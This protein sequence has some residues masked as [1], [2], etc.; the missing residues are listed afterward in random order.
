MADDEEASLHIARLMISGKIQNYRNILRRYIRDYGEEETII[1]ATGILERIKH[2]A[3]TATNKT[4]LMGYEGMASNTYF[5]VLPVLILNQKSDFPFHGRN[6]RPPKDAV[7]A[8]LSFVYTLIAN[9]VS[10]ALETVGLDP[11]VGFLHTLRPGRTSLALDM[12]EE[13]RAY[14]GD[15]FVLSLINKRQITS[16]DFLFQGDKGVVMTE[17]GKKNIYISLAEQET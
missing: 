14:L 11:Y 1:Y 16:K 7:N 3:L 6:R 9:D 5:E 4:T 17:K 15:R 2:D 8:M 10:A 13:L 12:M